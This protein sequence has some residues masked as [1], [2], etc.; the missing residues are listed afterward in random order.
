MTINVNQ[1]W[2]AYTGGWGAAAAGVAV[3]A[4][5]GASRASYQPCFQGVDVSYCSPDTYY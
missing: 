1:G 5:A 4:A 3:G 2:G